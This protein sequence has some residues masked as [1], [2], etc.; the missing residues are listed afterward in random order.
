MLDQ[1]TAITDEH[2]APLYHYCIHLDD[3]EY[4]NDHP[5]ARTD[6]I[7]FHLHHHKD[8]LY[9]PTDGEFLP[10]LLDTIKHALQAFPEALAA[11]L[12]A[13]RQLRADLRGYTFLPDPVPKPA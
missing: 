2:G 3:Y 12:E 5:D 6:V 7:T 1:N 4:S 9:E 11:A 8:D 10:A 13:T